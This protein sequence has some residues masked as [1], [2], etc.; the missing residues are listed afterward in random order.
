MKIKNI[1]DTKLTTRF[2]ITYLDILDESY[3][4]VHHSEAPSNG[5]SHFRIII[6]SPDFDKHSRLQRHREIY[7]CLEEELAQSVHALSI[8]AYTPE[9]YQKNN[10]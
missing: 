1:I 9:E 7:L 4:H 6:V 2:H 5:E 10:P 3:L 8:E